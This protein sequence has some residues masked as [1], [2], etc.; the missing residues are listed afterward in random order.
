M[1]AINL[2]PSIFP[3]PREQRYSLN[4]IANLVKAIVDLVTLPFRMIAFMFLLPIYL[5]LIMLHS[6]IEISL[7]VFMLFAFISVSTF[8]VCAFTASEIAV[9]IGLL[10]IGLISL[11]GLAALHR[12]SEEVLQNFSEAFSF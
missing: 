9:P 12:R 2:F 10:G 8:F 7:N 5:P 3:P 1:A 11:I 4:P 6:I